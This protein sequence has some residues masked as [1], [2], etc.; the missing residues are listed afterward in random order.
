MKLIKKWWTGRR[1]TC[2]DCGQI[3]D[4]E[5]TDV[6]RRGDFAKHEYRVMVDCPSC[7]RP[8]N[9]PTSSGQEVPR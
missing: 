3:F 8:V 6:P 5:E 4:L 1:L 2:R 9:V 7:G